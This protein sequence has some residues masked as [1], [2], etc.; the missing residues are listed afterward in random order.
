MQGSGRTVVMRADASPELGTGHVRRCLALA[1]SLRMRGARVHLVTR[2]H[3]AY[4]ARLL[5]D[6]GFPVV[7]LPGILGRQDDAAATHAAL[8]GLG[9]KPDWLIL[10]HYALDARWERR[11]R[12]SVARILVIDDLADRDHDTDVLIDP[13]LYKDPE[14][15]YAGKVPGHCRL[16]LGPRYALLRDEFRRTRSDAKPRT[17]EVGRILVFFGGGPRAAACSLAAIEALD[18]A[19]L[20]GAAVDVVFQAADRDRQSVAG[21]CGRRGYAFHHGTGRMADLM[22][23]ADFGIGAGGT[24]LWERC[25]VGLPCLTYALAENQRQQVREAAT[26]GVV[27]APG[28]AP[29]DTASL[30]RQLQ[31]CLENPS[32]LAAISRKAL[33]VV[34][35]RGLARVLRVLG[36]PSVRVRRA[37]SAD[38]R[39]MLDWRNEAGVRDASRD[40]D[41]I[42]PAEHESWFAS[43][44]ADPDKLLLI[45]ESEGRPV[46]V[47]R[48]D[49]DRGAAEISIYMLAGQAG[50][51]LG[52]DLLLAAEEMLLRARPDIKSVSAE[53]LAD[54]RSSH[55]LFV[56]C[57]YRL[58][59]STYAKR[60]A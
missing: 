14:R 12:P 44:L 16:L 32:L 2:P 18:D 3:A 15:R 27:I 26:A 11:L 56:S 13:N 23:Q 22:R 58:G 53:V 37:E 7:A 57:G 43:T 4:S 39:P 25:S 24:S 59:R 8:Q 21:A 29:D 60:I 5:D 34:D 30:G 28:T 45:G 41:L 48:F 36:M 52:A 6:C 20:H 40:S 38:C 55:E 54:N 1:E 50:R 49:I 46:G 10:D 35:G 17:G 31:S 42:E 47:V 9:V 51:G 19:D 33:S